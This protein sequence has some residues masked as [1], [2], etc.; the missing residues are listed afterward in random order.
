MTE[1]LTV[2][3][4]YPAAPVH[5]YPVLIVTQVLDDCP[6]PVPLLGDLAGPMLV[7]NQYPLAQTVRSKVPGV[8]AP[9]FQPSGE[10]GLHSQLSLLSAVHPD[11]GGRETPWLDRKKV[12]DRSTKDQLCGGEFV[13]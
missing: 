5:S 1:K 13:L 10:P 9:A 8:F 6:G 7:P 2:S 11:L 3:V 4:C 12:L